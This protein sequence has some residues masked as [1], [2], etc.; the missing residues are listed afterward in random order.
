MAR[1]ANSL[2]FTV[3]IA[4]SEVVAVTIGLS[5]NVTEREIEATEVQLVCVGLVEYEIP[6]PMDGSRPILD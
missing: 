6:N 2:A 5:Q 3:S 1:S 4:I